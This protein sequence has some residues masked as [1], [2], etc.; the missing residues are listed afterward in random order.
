MGL[1]AV[2]PAVLMFAILAN[3]GAAA[4]CQIACGPAP[5]VSV[6]CADQQASHRT[7]GMNHCPMCKPAQPDLAAGSC[8]TSSC[9][10]YQSAPVSAPAISNAHASAPAVQSAAATPVPST[11]S[12]LAFSETPPRLHPR[13]PV[14]L[15]TTLRI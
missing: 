2:L 3:A 1:K 15:H 10:C 14:S 6:S 12:Q 4:V 8:Q 11:P 5:G 9:I 13:S 7:A